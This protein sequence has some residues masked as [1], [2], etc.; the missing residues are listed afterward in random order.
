MAAAMALVPQTL[1]NLVED[2]LTMIGYRDL[3]LN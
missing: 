2:L 3:L 1:V